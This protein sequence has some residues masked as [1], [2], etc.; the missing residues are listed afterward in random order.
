M[1]CTQWTYLAIGS[2][3]NRSVLRYLLSHGSGASRCPKQADNLDPPPPPGGNKLPC[4]I[5]RLVLFVSPF[6]HAY[7]MNPSIWPPLL[8]KPPSH[9]FFGHRLHLIQAGCF[10]SAFI[11][12]LSGHLKRHRRARPANRQR[13]LF[14]G[15]LGSELEWVLL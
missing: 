5:L 8:Q 14:S 1:N 7:L 10:E 4:S 6:V 2:S 9:D 15:P 11:C 12:N 3:S 13:K